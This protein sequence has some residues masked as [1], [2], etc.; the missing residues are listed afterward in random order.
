V[1]PSRPPVD[2]QHLRRY[3]LGDAALEKEILD[4]FVGQAPVSVQQ[5]ATAQDA[6]SWTMAAHSLK[7]SA[8]SVGAMEVADLAAAAEGLG[9]ADAAG[10]DRAVA[11]L[12]AA[13]AAVDAF[14]CGNPHAPAG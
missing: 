1:T 13:V 8:R 4:L 3:T 2:L 7:G 9:Y 11:D 10:R 5:L 6:K 14:V 12:R